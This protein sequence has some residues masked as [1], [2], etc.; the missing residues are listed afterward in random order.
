M[1]I[2][3]N[4][5][6]IFIPSNLSLSESIIYALNTIDHM[7]ES[8]FILHGDTLFNKILNET[9]VF[10]VSSSDDNYSWGKVTEKADLVY[11][12]FFLFQAKRS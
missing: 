11:S 12:G 2:N 3:N 7:N 1:L 9:N 10:G 4:L 8:L 6:L 5:E